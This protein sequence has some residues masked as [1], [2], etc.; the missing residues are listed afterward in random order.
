MRYDVHLS[1]LGG[2]MGAPYNGEELHICYA[3]QFDWNNTYVVIV[4]GARLNPCGH[5]ILNVGGVGGN[6]FHI[7]A[8]RD[9]PRYMTEA[10]YRRY[11]KEEG[12]REIRRHPVTI[13]D[14][15]A[16][17]TK[18]DELLANKWSWFVLPHNCEAFVEDVVRAGGS[19]AGSYSNCPIG[20]VF[21]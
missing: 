20:E 6:Y 17:Q 7:A 10:G 1:S 9:F 4:S 19:K 2:R 5:A 14:P 8:V 13:R 21:R 3:R 18:L 12:K 15:Y 11:L 16:A